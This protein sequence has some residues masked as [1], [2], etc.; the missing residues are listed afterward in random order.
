MKR[1]EFNKEHLKR[2]NLLLIDKKFLERTEVQQL[3]KDFNFCSMT[4]QRE[5]LKNNIPFKSA[6]IKVTLKSIGIENDG[7]SIEYSNLQDLD[8]WKVELLN[9]SK[10]IIKFKC[11]CCDK[12]SVLPANNMLRRKYLNFE[13][14]CAKCIL[15]ETTNLK[16]WKE[17]NSKA[18]FISQNIP[19]RLEQ[20]RK[21]S[22]ELQKNEHYVKRRNEGI[23][24]IYIFHRV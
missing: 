15:K 2:I 1:K 14:I 3:I 8:K 12:N 10:I 20:N 18:Q 11:K 6:K 16:E 5:L 21:N 7:K 23:K 22:L 24:R 9:D 19:V 4:M 17:K 13:S